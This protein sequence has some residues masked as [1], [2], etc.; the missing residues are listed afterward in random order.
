MGKNNFWNDL[1]NS[2]RYGVRF[3]LGEGIDISVR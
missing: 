2:N 1:V 3:P